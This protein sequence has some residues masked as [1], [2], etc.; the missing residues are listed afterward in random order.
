MVALQVQKRRAVVQ[1]IR[2]HRGDSTVPQ[3]K[4]TVEDELHTRNLSMM[5]EWP[6]HNS[7]RRRDLTPVTWGTVMAGNLSCCSK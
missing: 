1:F 2:G 6:W 4:R 7:L 5:V 3:W